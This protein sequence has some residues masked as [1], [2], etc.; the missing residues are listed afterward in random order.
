MPRIA[1][2][3]APKSTA[4]P[5]PGFAEGA[6]Q[7][8]AL[9]S[10]ETPDLTG[11][12]CPTRF[13]T[14]QFCAAYRSDEIVAPVVRGLSWSHRAVILARAKLLEERRRSAQRSVRARWSRRGSRC[15]LAG[16]DP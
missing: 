9:I 12:T 3:S 4:V 8:A 1:Q 7:T 16:G 6:A 5:E 15:V 14:K 2:P 10:R 13:G 11:S